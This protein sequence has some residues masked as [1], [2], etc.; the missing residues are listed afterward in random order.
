MSTMISTKRNLRYIR[1]VELKT[2]VR[3]KTISVSSAEL[4]EIQKELGSLMGKAVDAKLCELFG[5]PL[6]ALDR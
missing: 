2:G 3:P 4:K 5:V 1:E 6:F